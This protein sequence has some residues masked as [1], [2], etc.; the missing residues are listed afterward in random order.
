MP[1]FNHSQFRLDRASFCQKGI[2]VILCFLLASLAASAACGI[3][4]VTFVHFSY[5]SLKESGG[6]DPYHNAHAIPTY[7]AL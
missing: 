7:V 1:M 6:A 4:V 2:D 5:W 3:S